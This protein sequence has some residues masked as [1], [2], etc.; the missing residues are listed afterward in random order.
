[1][2]QPRPV[3]LPRETRRTALVSESPGRPRAGKA[4]GYLLAHVPHQA[5]KFT[6]L[7]SVNPQQRH[8]W[9]GRPGSGGLDRLR[10]T[11]IQVAAGYRLAV[12]PL[13]GLHFRARAQ[14]PAGRRD[15][16]R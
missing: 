10:R 14:P 1:M 2:W 5:A 15:L 7:A 3:S 6:S 13:I 9:A 8:L 16:Y 12:I 4:A 11:A